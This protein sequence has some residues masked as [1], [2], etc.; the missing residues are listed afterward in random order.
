M[1]T[2]LYRPNCYMCSIAC[3]TMAFAFLSLPRVA[4][5]QDPLPALKACSP[6][7]KIIDGNNKPRGNWVLDPSMELDVYYAIRS[8]KD[9]T[10]TFASDIDS[11]S[12]DVS[13]G[14]AYDFVIVL[15]GKDKCKTRISTVA[16]GLE[17]TDQ[18]HGAGALTIPITMEN[19]KLHIKG[20][21]NGSKTLDMIFDTGADSCVIYPSARSKGVELKM[22]DS[23]LN[24]GT[25][26]VT[27]RRVSRDNRIEIADARWNHVPLVCVEKQ[28]DRSDAIIGYSLFEDR[29]VE[30]DY[31]RMLMLVHDGL[32]PHA[33]EFSKTEMPYSGTLPSV[34]I[35]MAD[36][37]RSYRGN[38]ILDTAA[39]GSM[40]VNQAFAMDH[41]MHGT[42]RKVGSG[43]SRGV[44]S[45]S[46]RSNQL[47]LPTLS[48]A[49]HSLRDVPL[50]VE[51]PSNANQAPPGGVVCMDVLCRLNSILDFPAGE[52]YF[53]PNTRFSEPIKIRG[54][55]P[56]IQSIAAIVLTAFFTALTVWYL[57]RKR[58]AMRNF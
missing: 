50:H 21:V 30:L 34:E 6:N 31:D 13:P 4:S 37:S 23:I 11:L 10:I 32:P 53:R 24:S 25:G 3:A 29:V 12:F 33:S 36:G 26:G 7:V 22:D 5:A 1:Q 49:G 14:Q 38:F 35:I 47:M 18:S 45:G 41:N 27:L 2:I 15:N 44:G 55:G 17:R 28:A 51:L 58:N 46:I 57:A 9:R 39:N 20:R 56:S 42:L 48:I 40:L 8:D 43:V 54:S 16:Q 52:A 19:G